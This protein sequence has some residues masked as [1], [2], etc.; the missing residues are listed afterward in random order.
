MNYERIEKYIECKQYLHELTMILEILNIFNNNI[1]EINYVTD[2]SGI[3]H[4]THP[5][6]RYRFSFYKDDGS[7]GAGLINNFI[8]RN[9]FNSLYVTKSQCSKNLTS[10]SE[11]DFCDIR[12]EIVEKCNKLIG[13]IK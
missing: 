10:P 2:Y 7:D 8:M 13:I 3:A 5:S 6:L 12:S 11:I 4:L 9:N 1:S